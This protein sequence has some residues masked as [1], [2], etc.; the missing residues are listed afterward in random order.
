M[1]KEIRR[2]VRRPIS[3]RISDIEK[4]LV[5]NTD[6]RWEIAYRK[7]VEDERRRIV[8]ILKRYPNY[9]ISQVMDEIEKEGKG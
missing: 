9:I 5:Q 8:K 6:G 3:V 2:D 7:G 4:A 1:T